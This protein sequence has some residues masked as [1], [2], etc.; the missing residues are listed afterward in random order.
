[1]EQAPLRRERPDAHLGFA[2]HP[3]VDGDRLVCLTAAG[4]DATVT[5]FDKLNGDVVWKAL[6][7]EP[8]YARR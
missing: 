7:R 6:A 8:G 2:G 1:M 3:L 4:A 5:A